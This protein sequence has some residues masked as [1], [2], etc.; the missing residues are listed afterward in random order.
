[1]F[2][3]VDP[4]T[5][6]N[7]TIIEENESNNKANRS[8]QVSL[9]HVFAG[10]TTGLIRIEMQ[11]VNDSMYIWNVSNYTGSNIYVTDLEANPNFLRLQAIG[12][13]TSNTTTVGDFEEIDAKLGTTNFTDSINSTYTYDGS[14]RATKQFIVFSKA[15]NGVPIINSTNST[16]FQTGMLW[17]TNDGGLEYNASQD[18]IFVTETNQQQ[19]GLNGIYD[20]EI[21]VP[22]LLRNY[23]AAGSSVAF[24]VELK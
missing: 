15:I 21:K 17:D 9:Y 2:V 16:T 7:G 22:A 24:Y 6:T 5:A 11:S 8:L 3:V 4:P 19:E 1:V 14:P 23:N 10:N 18:L 12:M 13:N 20:F